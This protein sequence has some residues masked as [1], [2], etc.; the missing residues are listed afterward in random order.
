MVSTIET[1]PLTTIRTFIMVDVPA[2]AIRMVALIQILGQRI[3][4]MKMAVQITMIRTEGQRKILVC[5]TT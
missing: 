3:L 5:E 4:I 2:T 1:L